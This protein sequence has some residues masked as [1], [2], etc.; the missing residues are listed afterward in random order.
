MADKNSLIES[1][2]TERQL[3][4]DPVKVQEAYVKTK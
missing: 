2:F 3:S 1:M 4:L